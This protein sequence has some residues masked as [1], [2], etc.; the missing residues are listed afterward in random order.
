[1]ACP[2]HG[3]GLQP[4]QLSMRRPK[5]DVLIDRSREILPW[6]CCIRIGGFPASKVSETANLDLMAY[7]FW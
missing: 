7:P 2:M 3:N 6:T 4:D 5:A 1:M